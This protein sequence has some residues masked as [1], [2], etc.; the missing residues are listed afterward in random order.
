MGRKFLTLGF[1]IFICLF[2]NGFGAKWTVMVYLD[3]DNDLEEFAINDFLEMASIGSNENVN[4]V[5]Q[6]DR[7]NGYDRRFDNWTECNR[8]YVTYGMIPTRANSIKNW[9]DGIGGREVNMGDPQTLI[10][11][12]NWAKINYP[13]EKYALILWNHGSGWRTISILEE[14]G[15]KRI[16]YK[17]VCYDDTSND[18]LSMKEVRSALSNNYFDLIGFDACLMGMIEVATE[19]KE[20]ANIFVSSESPETTEGWNYTGFLLSLKNN[21][22]ATAEELTF[23]IINST[24]QETLAGIKLNK[25]GQLNQKLNQLLN[26]I[27]NLNDYLPI[28]LAREET[29]IFDS[30]FA[31]IYNFW[32]NYYLIAENYNIKNLIEEFQIIFNQAVICDKNPND[33]AYGLTIYFPSYFSSID[34]GYNENTIIFPKETMWD[35]FLYSFFSSNLF[36]GYIKIFS[37]DFSNGLPSNWE[38]IDG[39]NDGFTWM[40][41]NPKN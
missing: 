31:D 17:E 37:E 27:I 41:Q 26:E 4:I 35:E 36:E 9:G 32:E 22:N 34:P 1:F 15:K 8:F 25:I 11:F 6:F 33:K 18:Y 39:F 21:P 3:G 5:V 12:I 19:I 10:D 24:N 13:A 23:Y 38:I 14:I 20:F 2:L 29:L 30:E 28:F 40:S 7:I 16:P